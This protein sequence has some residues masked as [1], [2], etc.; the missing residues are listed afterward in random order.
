MHAVSHEVS[1]IAVVVKIAFYYLKKSDAKL[2]SF[3]Y[4]LP[5]VFVLWSVYIRV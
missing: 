3:S 5:G 1:Y 4:Q 2:M